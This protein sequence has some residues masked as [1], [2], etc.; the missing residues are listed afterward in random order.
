LQAL[1]EVDLVKLEL[2]AVKRQLAL[3]IVDLK[4]MF[5]NLT[6]H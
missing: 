2:R 1:R 6:G 5:Y 4:Y 3:Q